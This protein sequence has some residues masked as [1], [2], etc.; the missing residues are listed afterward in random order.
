[1]LACLPPLL[2]VAI[3][4]LTSLAGNG[5]DANDR[6]LLFSFDGGDT[7]AGPFMRPQNIA[8]D[9]STGDV[10]VINLAGEGRGPGSLHTRRAVDK[11]DAKGDAK[12]FSPAIGSSLSCWEEK[13]GKEVCLGEKGFFG[14]GAL[15]ADLA[16]D[17]SAVHPGR[18]YVNEH[19]G[20]L[21]AFDPNG[22]HL[23]TLPATT[24]KPCGIAV[25]DRG[26]LWVVEVE[27]ARE[28]VIEFTA[29]GS[30][31][32]KI[33]SFPLTANNHPCRPAVDGAGKYLYVA[34]RP[35]FYDSLGV[36]KY[37]GGSHDSSLDGAKTLE[38]TIDQSRPNGHIFVRHT[39]DFAEYEPCTKPE[40]RSKEVEGSPF[41]EGEIEENLDLGGIAYNP[42]RDWVY[43]S[44]VVPGTVRV[45][46]PRGGSP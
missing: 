22:K 42:A 11:F 37:A 4:A 18:L 31:P 19:E 8:V 39:T 6:P 28:E 41:G 36:E 40:C 17:N 13:S 32:P 21:H 14:T 46:G 43:V 27:G 34:D 5:S 9:E 10:Y 30:P 45:F 33:D 16:V 24:F 3:L 20:P 44:D 23:W 26:H 38:V 29:N 7:T 15:N 1:M 25:D 12:D 2:V 35:P